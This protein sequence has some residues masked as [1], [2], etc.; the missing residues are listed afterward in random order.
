MSPFFGTVDD[1]LH[2]L[3][4]AIN[5]LFHYADDLI[6]K[7]ANFT[8]CKGLYINGERLDSRLASLPQLRKI[9][10]GPCIY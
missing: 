6:D 9:L 3:K 5:Q 10:T 2:Y 1:G 8:K 4:C 7:T